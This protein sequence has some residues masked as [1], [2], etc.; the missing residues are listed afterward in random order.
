MESLSET[1]SF[2]FLFF[3]HRLR[4]FYPLIFRERVEGRERRREKE[5]EDG[6]EREKKTSM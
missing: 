5:R 4:I 2:H 6:R 1:V 3:N